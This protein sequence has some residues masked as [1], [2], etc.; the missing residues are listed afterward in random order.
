LDHLE[1]AGKQAHVRFDDPDV[2]IVVETIANWAG[3]TSIT[4]ELKGKYP[5]VKV[6]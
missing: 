1:K 5:L 6:K 4:R 2:I 3:V